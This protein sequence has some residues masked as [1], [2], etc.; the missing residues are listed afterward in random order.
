MSW[1]R[2]V[3]FFARRESAHVFALFRASIGGVVFW[4][5]M[6]LVVV[7]GIEPLWLSLDDGGIRNLGEGTW[8]LRALGLPVSPQVIWT[9]IALTLGGA[10]LLV[11]GLG[12]R[13]SAFVTLQGFMA[14]VDLHA[15]A[16]GSYDELQ[17]NALW[18]LVLGNSTATWSVDARLNTGS[19][20]PDV[21]IGA[22]V[23]YLVVFQLMLMYWTTGLQKVSAY[24]IPGGEMSALY[25]IMQQPTWQRIDM[26]WVAWIFPLTQLGSLTSWLWEITM[27]VFGLAFVLS[28][29]RD[30]PGRVAR[31]MA[32]W[33]V[34]SLYAVIGLTFHFIIFATMNVGPFT[35]ASLAFYVCL[36]HPWEARAIWDR[37]HSGT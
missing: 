5:V 30:A 3:D 28:L 35:V 34:R 25:Y 14:L 13:L 27:P 9:L 2:F 17:A 10:V 24:W 26:S 32:R 11:I 16:G 7:G 36:I 12:G 19:W 6:S 15:G 31:W 4:S 33:R 37:W 8:L 23:R 1:G 21:Q 18:I 29:N 20:A 22:W